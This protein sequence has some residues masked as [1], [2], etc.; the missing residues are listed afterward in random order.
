MVAQ[1]Q[2]FKNKQVKTTTSY[3]FWPV[4]GKKIKR[5]CLISYTK[6]GYSVRQ[7]G[8]HL[9][10]HTKVAETERLWVQGKPL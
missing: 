6:T 4:E 2:M 10:S 9:K 1:Q 7:G 5:R 8:A 3:T